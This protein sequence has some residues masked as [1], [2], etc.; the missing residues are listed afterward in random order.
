MDASQQINAFQ[1]F[2]ELNYQAEILE[3]TRKGE[4]HL[5]IDFKKLSEFSPEISE[6]ILD[7]P[8]EA[9]KAAQIAIEQLNLQE[10]QKEFHIRLKNI[11]ESQR[12]DIRDIR[13]NHI[14]KLLE[15]RGIVRQKS[16]VRPQVTSAKFECPACNNI[17]PILQVEQKFREP[18]RCGCGRKG[19]FYLIDKELV[20][21]QKIVLEESPDELDGGEQPKRISIFL[22]NDLVSPI[23][24]KK[25]NPGSKILITGVVNEVPIPSRD[26]GKLTRFDLLVD[27]NYVEPM[28]EDFSQIDVNPQEVKKIKELSKNPRIYDMLIQSLAPSIYGYE[29]VKQALL[30]QLFGGNRKVRSDG[31]A[32]RGDTH[33][34][35]VG[36]PGAGK[37][38]LLTR[39]SKIAPKARF[40]S[41]KGA[42]GAGL[43]ASVVKDEFLGGWA[44][45]A[46]ALVLA[47][48]GLCMIDE[49]DKMTKEDRSAMHEALE[50]QT[51][52]I[53]KA[54]IQAT[55]RSETTVL[56]AANPKYGRFDPF[57]TIPK[58]I[59]LP[60]TLL[61]RFDLI[62]PIRDIPHKDRDGDMA[63]F[64]LSLHKNIDLLKG[65]EEIDSDLFKKYISYAKQ[66]VRPV[67]TD[68]A[69]EEIQNYYVNMRNS[70][71][72]GEYSAIPISPRQLEALIRL[73]EASAKIRL[74]DKV[75]IIDA[76][77]AIDL[78]HHCLSQ[79]G[80]DPSTGKIDIDRIS[81]GTTASERS[82]MHLIKEI[83]SE[84]E[85]EIG[86][87]Q[88]IPV[89]E[90]MR[91]CKQKGISEEK[92]N[93]IIEKLNRTGDIFTPRP[94]FIKKM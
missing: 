18:S 29:L 74:S 68:E 93:E 34:L 62:F 94:G 26:G 11:P 66:R 55:L 54:N 22:K 53:N 42:S 63:K 4:T 1:E 56:A 21:A 36:D 27:V 83:I 61:N 41:G 6:Q 58:Q 76:K 92:V 60:S 19:K 64:I 35:L 2:F 30:F 86:G 10:S 14:S 32:T 44:L 8:I 65:K 43:T 73:A 72:E 82:S 28:Q 49:L 25:T 77:K 88:P 12:V 46:G 39:M 51:V 81:G 57:E 33:I 16:D 31:V 23:S 20:D 45:E 80:L 48:K 70:S 52:T 78:V 47:N 67:L 90:I 85:K 59:D 50:Q 5:T 84:L 17:I 9:L 37:S 40:V 87:D 91:V 71:Q 89:D 69:I 75:T 24:E 38:Q 15:I 79:I 13:S 7:D 3:T